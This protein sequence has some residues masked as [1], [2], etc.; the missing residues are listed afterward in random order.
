MVTHPRTDSLLQPWINGLR[1]STLPSRVS[2][3]SLSGSSITEGTQRLWLVFG[4]R[5]YRKVLGCATTMHCI[6]R[7]T[8]LMHLVGL[9]WDS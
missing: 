7:I 8:L 6:V 5:I 3:V 4:T 1:N 9:G 2:R